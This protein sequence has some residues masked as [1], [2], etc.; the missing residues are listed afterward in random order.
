MVSVVICTYNR[1]ESL[2]RVLADLSGIQPPEGHGL[3]V[4]VVDNG[5]SDHTA[6]LVHAT[7]AGFPWPLRYCLEP[8]RGQSHA[9]NRGIQ[10]AAGDWIAFTDDDVRVERQW[11]RRLIRG[12]EANLAPAVGGRVQPVWP[13][14]LPRWV[15]TE[16]RFLQGI[17]FLHYE[18]AGRGRL[19][20]G[21]D[22]N[23]VGCNMAFRA[24][25][26]RSHGLFSLCLGHCGGRL[27]GGEDTE[28]LGRIRLAGVPVYYAA[29][30]LIRH[31]VPPDRV[32]LAFLLRRRFWEGYGL[33][34]SA[35]PYRGSRLL[36]VPLYFFRGI[37]RAGRCCLGAVLRREWAAAAHHAGIL[38]GRL[39]FL[40]GT[41]CRLA[42]GRRDRVAPPEAAA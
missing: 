17:V 29:D 19:L 14:V 7:A 25:L 40:W 32:S 1:A 9:R 16:G 34:K 3:E 6:A 5:S 30:A 4:L 38:G 20:A 27:V 23:P 26:F 12:A 24:E 42:F 41:W 33:A 36:G 10:E 13:A 35:A 28:F 8:T 31:P 22:P 21:A 18:P 11:L 2:G 37:L 15:A 39:G